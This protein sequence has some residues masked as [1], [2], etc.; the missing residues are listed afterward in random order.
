MKSFSESRG[1]L[2]IPLIT[3]RLK[4]NSI[5]YVTR[6]EK[7]NRLG[8]FVQPRISSPGPAHQRDFLLDPSVY[9]AFA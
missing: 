8:G 6:E 2:D 1:S 4:L 5:L 7:I 9:F 3:A